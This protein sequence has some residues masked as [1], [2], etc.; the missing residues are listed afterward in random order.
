[1]RCVELGGAEAVGRLTSL[2]YVLFMGALR[3]SSPPLF[4]FFYPSVQ[5]QG[6]VEALRCNS[7]LVNVEAWTA[8]DFFLYGVFFD[9]SVAVAVLRW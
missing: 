9:I 4:F 3:C 8:T 1:M 5:L 7:L 6:A 2:L